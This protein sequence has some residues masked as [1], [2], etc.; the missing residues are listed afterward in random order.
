MSVSPELLSYEKAYQFQASHCNLEKVPST[1]YSDQYQNEW[2]SFLSKSTGII[3]S[4]SSFI[5]FI[6]HFIFKILILTKFS[7][8]SPILLDQIADLTHL[9]LNAIRYTA[10][11]VPRALIKKIKKISPFQ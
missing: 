8:D 2:K 10:G 11:Y 9:E 3:Q 1:S 7:L 4:S 5:Q 6:G